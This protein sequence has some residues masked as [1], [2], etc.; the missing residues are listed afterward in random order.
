MTCIEAALDCNTEIDAAITEAAHD[1]LTQPMED[2][3]TDHAMTHLTNHIADLPN[4]EALQVINPKIIVGHTHNHPINF[5]DMNCI[6]H[7]HNPAEQGENHIP[8]RT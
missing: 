1:H 6:N 2:T 5:Q 7:V 3:A 4:I 8:R